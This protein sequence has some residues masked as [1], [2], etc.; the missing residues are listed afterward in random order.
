MG[1]GA[2]LSIFFRSALKGCVGSGEEP[3]LAFA[4]ARTPIKI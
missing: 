1:L 2:P 3:E 4:L